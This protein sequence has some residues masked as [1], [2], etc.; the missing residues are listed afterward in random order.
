MKEAALIRE[1]SQ[2]KIHAAS[3]LADFPDNFPGSEAA[4][5][6]NTSSN[7]VMTRFSRFLKVA[8][9]YIIHNS[10]FE[11]ECSNHSEKSRITYGIRA[12]L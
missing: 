12:V 1:K 11:P 10:S 5:R 9:K 8:G 2:Q 7:A 3:L 4:R 6:I